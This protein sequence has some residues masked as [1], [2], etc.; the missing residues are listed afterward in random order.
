VLEYLFGLDVHDASGQ[1]RGDGTL[2]RGGDTPTL[3]VGAAVI[4]EQ[5]ARRRMIF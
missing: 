4:D 3:G 5:M 2:E 1:V